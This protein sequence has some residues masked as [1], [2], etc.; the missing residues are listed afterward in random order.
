MTKTIGF[1]NRKIRITKRTA[2]IA[3]I[4][5]S[6]VLLVVFISMAAGHHSRNVKMKE[7]DETARQIFVVAQNDLTKAKET[8]VLDSYYAKNAAGNRGAEIIR[9][10]GSG[11]SYYCV[12]YVPGGRTDL[13][14][15]VLKEMLPKGS[16]NEAVRTGGHYII[17]Y[18]F[19]SAR[20]IGVFYTDSS[21]GLNESTL[22]TAVRSSDKERMKY[23]SSETGDPHVI[24]YCSGSREKLSAVNLER[25][26][27][28]VSNGDRLTVTVT[29]PNYFTR[30]KKGNGSSRLDTHMSIN[31]VGVTSGN[32]QTLDLDLDNDKVEPENSDEDFWT[33]KTVRE[34]GRRVLQ[35]T[36]TLDDITRKGCHFA[37][38][39]D[40]LK[41]G[42]NIE[43]FA[44]VSTTNA[45]ASP[46]LSNTGIS[47]SL[48]SRVT[49]NSSNGAS[50]A[51]V[52]SIRHLE[53]LDPDVSGI[54]A[55]PGGI[56]A[57]V[58]QTGDIDWKKFSNKERSGRIFIY[59][60]EKNG[61]LSVLSENS[62]YSINSSNI[63]SYNGDGKTI[64]NLVVRNN[65]LHNKTGRNGEAGGLFGS[66]TNTMTMSNMV[67]EN[68]DVT[69]VRYAGALA[70]R[71]NDRANGSVTA[72]NVLVKN[73][74]VSSAISG[75]GSAGGLI[76]CCDSDTGNLVINS[77][78]STAVVKSCNGNA[79]G[80]VGEVSGLAQIQNSYSGGHT[81]R[82]SYR[83][84]DFNIS[85][86]GRALFGAELTAGSGG[87]IGRISSKASAVT[88]NNCNST[89]SAAGRNAGGLVGYDD[90]KGA[91]HTYTG[92]YAAGL[93]KG[94]NSGAFAGHA[95]DA[96][97]KDSYYLSGIN[98]RAGAFG[99]AGGN[100]GSVTASGFYDTTKIARD[101]S[102]LARETHT[103]DSAAGGA[104]YPFAMVNNAGAENKESTFVHYGD[105]Q[106]PSDS[107]ANISGNEMFA[108][109]EGSK[110]SYRWKILN[111]SVT[112]DRKVSVTTVYDDLYT[113][114]SRTE[115]LSDADTSYGRLCS[116]R[117]DVSDFYA[118]PEKV[119]ID[120]RTL[121]YYRAARYS[122]GKDIV[123]TPG[124]SAG[125][126]I[127]FSYSFN[128]KFA[129][130][131]ESTGAWSFG[132]E[133]QPYQ[134]RTAGQLENVNEYRD[135]CFWQS[136]NIKLTARY[137]RPV[138]EGKFKGTYNATRSGSSRGYAVTGL[139]E[140]VT[141]GRNS[142][143]FARVDSSGSITGL[144]L[145]GRISVKLKSADGDA[146]IGAMAGSNYGSIRNSSVDADIAVTCEG[147]KDSA[148]MGIMA[149]SSGG[150][151]S[152]ENCRAAGSLKF[153]GSGSGYL[154]AG[155]FVGAAN[156]NYI[157]SG[158]FAMHNC[159]SD[160]DI[161]VNYD[162]RGTDNSNTLCSIGGLV[163]YLKGGAV[164]LC[165]TISRIDSSSDHNY[166]GGLA[167]YVGSYEKSKVSSAIIDQCWSRAYIDS[168]S[169]SGWIAG[170][171]AHTRADGKVNARISN[172]YA[173]TAFDSGLKG[174][175]ILFIGGNE[176]RNTISGCH[177]IEI[178]SIKQ[179]GRVVES[180]RTFIGGA[181]LKADSHCYTCASA[182]LKQPGVN[183]L[184]ADKF[185]SMSSFSNWDSSTW[186]VVNDRYPT[187]TA[188]PETK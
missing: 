136:R 64:K 138:I 63:T 134:V 113:G 33:V 87:L 50:T 121:Y 83:T 111:A 11:S 181:R 152:F 76:G 14:N 78:G 164:S 54:E 85:G 23:K 40:Q 22:T 106:K 52:S 187:L 147:L 182:S 10:N 103:S 60:Y 93:V 18:D 158:T 9:R 36:V 74:R 171:V 28:T 139:D 118:E 159:E 186:E 37:E 80:L 116:S 42:E 12:S 6:A 173:A 86:T 183:Y 185:G 25:P 55:V 79:G 122:T 131:M 81:D 56:A 5:V 67:L 44:S 169:E 123:E 150:T 119:S 90:S 1:N 13:E 24:G 120:G 21:Q 110:G 180:G 149:G 141:V 59:G 175:A 95:N 7:L 178:S 108:Y 143:L 144:Q 34:G 167:G 145:E 68:F 140:K 19:D 132:T 51:E 69:A 20:V 41:P 179:R 154:R 47:N 32:T 155:G 105:W 65:V 174:T 53:N 8:G 126:K 188:A 27:L 157:D 73:G 177:G 100:S 43:V 109:R 112:G 49:V 172:S 39:F 15:T 62:F 104:R 82:G 3:M 66:V 135:K 129:A 153:K 72:F 92:C 102:S 161:T 168:S 88:M 97:F 162:N 133:D 96:V 70:G 165:G 184:D 166:I 46:Q 4:A 45:A 2:L 71:V 98:G 176:A 35:Y 137:K 142:G 148:S 16:I 89:C 114:T 101:N 31:V 17:E 91:L 75:G 163:G 130:A 26:A 99:S 30:I 124:I 160:S 125:K 156:S 94:Q 84:D 77:C 48:F 128:R 61:S 57:S 29:D 170:F 38:L 117:I 151:G 127:S 58:L 107:S 146:D 115:Y